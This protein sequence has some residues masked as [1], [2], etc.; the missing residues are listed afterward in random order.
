ASTGNAS[1][2]R[3]AARLGTMDREANMR[4]TLT[5]GGRQPRPSWGAGSA[6]HSR[7]RLLAFAPAHARSG[8]G[9][10]DSIGGS[11]VPLRAQQR[12]RR[13]EREQAVEQGGAAAR[14]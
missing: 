8:S 1:Q 5:R 11:R 14:P 9:L 7:P 2:L 6:L 10:A 4:E 12:P 13:P 3:A